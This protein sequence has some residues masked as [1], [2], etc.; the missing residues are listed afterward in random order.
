MVE[1]EDV[2]VQVALQVLGADHMVNAVN[3]ALG[4]A[5]K[6]LNVIGMDIAGDVLLGGVND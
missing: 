6:T 5:P 3:P 2:G 4:V 1:P